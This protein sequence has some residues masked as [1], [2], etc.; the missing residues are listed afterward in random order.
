[1]KLP[2]I[3]PATFVSVVALGVF[4]HLW[5]ARF[6]HALQPG[7]LSAQ[8]ARIPMTIGDWDGMDETATLPEGI[9]EI[10][11]PTIVRRY[12]NRRTGALVTMS[13]TA[14][15]PGP[16]FVNHQP[17]TCYTGIGY[18]VDAGPGQRSVALDNGSAGFNM[19]RFVKN[20]GPA[21]R[22][23]RLYWGYTGD[24]NW[25]APRSPRVT[26]ARFPVVFKMYV[27][28]HLRKRTDPPETDPAEEFIRVLA[29]AIKKSLFDKG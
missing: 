27:I 25:Q 3:L 20:A 29:P 6:A 15:R 18:E 19:V 2:L 14:D 11:G 5:S 23:L 24:G 26:F 1:V 22:Y 16:I 28:H 8:M 4:Q 12:V 9:P 13:L 7:V 17:T 21:P 10:I